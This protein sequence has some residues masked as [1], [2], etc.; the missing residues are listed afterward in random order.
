MVCHVVWLLGAVLLNNLC[1]AGTFEP[2]QCIGYWPFAPRHYRSAL[3]VDALS[4]ASFVSIQH[5][6][7]FARGGR[8]RFYAS[9]AEIR[10]RTSNI[11]CNTAIL[12]APRA[13]LMRGHS[14]EKW[15]G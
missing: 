1:D 6:Y 9:L 10:H 3:L 14:P 13:F 8:P 5:F 7:S 11:R 2:D 4:G 12:D 15:S